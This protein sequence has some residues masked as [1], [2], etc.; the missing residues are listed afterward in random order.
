MENPYYKNK[1][2][3]DELIVEALKRCPEQY[4]DGEIIEVR[5]TLHRIVCAIDLF[6]RDYDV[7][8]Q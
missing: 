7:D 2:L 3:Q 1:E 6:T 4:E 5:D 8:E